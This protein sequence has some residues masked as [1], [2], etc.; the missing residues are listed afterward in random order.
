MTTQTILPTLAS[1][2]FIDAVKAAI[3]QAEYSDDECIEY[4]AK[5][6][7]TYVQYQP[8]PQQSRAGGC[9]H[10]ASLGSIAGMAYGYCAK[11]YY[12]RVCPYQS[13]RDCRFC[14][15]KGTLIRPDMNC[16]ACTFLGLWA[17]YWPGYERSPHG[18]IFLFEDGIRKEIAKKRE[19]GLNSTLQEEGLRVFL[20]EVDHAL[21]RDHVLEALGKTGP[22]ARP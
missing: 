11:C 6:V 9:M 10:C 4:C 13:F 17:S 7:P 18:I 19:V 20:H 1:A 22:N 14:T 2:E 3:L 8:T 21:Q 15:E 5:A 12:A 16:R